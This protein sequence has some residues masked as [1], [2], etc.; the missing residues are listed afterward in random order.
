MAEMS[1]SGISLA[2]AS[3]GALVDTSRYTGP[4]AVRSWSLTKDGSSNTSVMVAMA[5]CYV[6]EWYAY[7]R[8][9]TVASLGLG[10]LIVG[11]SSGY[12]RYTQ[13]ETLRN[14]QCSSGNTVLRHQG[15]SQRRVDY[16]W[17]RSAASP[18]LLDALA[19]KS[20]LCFN[21][22]IQKYDIVHHIHSMGRD[23][24]DSI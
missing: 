15:S 20:H 22:L 21:G 16:L 18:E 17:S 7:A 2:W 4:Y 24:M 9:V 10:R 8:L 5:L 19:P 13:F 6:C 23:R 1:I 3:L 12:S 11:I 14:P